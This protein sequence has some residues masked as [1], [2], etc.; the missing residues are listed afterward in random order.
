MMETKKS[1]EERLDKHRSRLYALEQLDIPHKVSQIVDEVVADAVD[2]AMQAPLRRRFSDL[3]VVDMKLALHQRMY[4]DESYETHEDHKNLFDA[5]QKSLERDHSD[6][7]A[8]DLKEA[9]PFSPPP[10]P[11]PAGG[12]GAPGTSGGSGLSQLPPTPPNPSSGTSRYFQQ[13]GGQAPSSS[14]SA[15]PAQQ[16]MAWTTTDTQYESIGITE[17]QESSPIES[18][19]QDESISDE[20]VNL[21]DDEDSKNNHS[22]NADSRKDWWK[23]LPEEDRHATPK[24]TWIIPSSNTSDIVNN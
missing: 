23:P 18:M 14:K 6:Q 7:L 19:M 20:Q 16:S 10:P 12:S 4:E 5:L 21:S 1:L 13:Q 9:F 17:G 11:P 15:D 22:P 8:S 2:W 24:P 3:P